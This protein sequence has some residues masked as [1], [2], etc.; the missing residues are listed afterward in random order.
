MKKL[1]FLFFL[2]FTLC[3]TGLI[4]QKPYDPKAI[5]PPSPDV[6]TGTLPNG[7]KYYIKFNQKPAQKVELRLAVNAGSILEDNDQQ[8][9]AHFMEHMNF[10][11]LKHF[12]ANELVQYLQSIGVGFGNDLNAF[13]GFDETQYML[14][15][16]SDDSNKVDK[17]FTVISDWSG[18][19]LLTTE[20]I[21]KERGVIL[22]ES[23]IGKGADDR[24]M[25]K[26]LPSL[27]N[28]SKYA[29]RLPIGADSIIEKF[30]YSV[31]RRFYTDW[32]RPNLQAVIVV[33]DMPVEKAEKM[34]AEKFGNFKNPA[35]PRPRQAIFEV[36]PFTVSKA[37]MVSDKEANFTQISIVCSA[38]PSHPVITEGDFLNRMINNLFFSMMSMRL[39]ELKNSAKPPF[40]YAYTYLGGWGRGY[41]NFA[42][43]A[44]C[45]NQQMKPAIEA[46]MS[47]CMRVKKFGLTKDE[48]SRA[49]AMMLADYEKRYN[50]RNKT[51][52][53]NLIWQFASNFYENEAIPG[54]EWERNFVKQNIDLIDLNSF[55]SI[56][57]KITFNDKYFCYVTAK[58]EADLPTDEQLKAWIDNALKKN[59]EAYKENA[60]AASLL[61]AEPK[62]GTV[63]NTEKNEKLGTTTLTLS[64]GAT[65]CLKQTDFKNDEIIF[66]G[67]RFGG[68]SLY[69]AIDYPSAQFSNN[70]VEEMGYGDFSKSDLTK[71]LSGKE[72]SVTPTIDMYT[73]Y[74]N[75]KSTVKDLETLFQLIYLKC[76]SPRK[77]AEAF[78]SYISREKQQLESIKQNPQYLFM[79]TAYNTFYG[80]N[81]R[82]H[83]LE[84][85]SIYNLMK[86]ENALN[87]YKERL[88]NVN[89]MYYTFVG[90]FTIDQILP[91]IQK[92]IA[93]LPSGNSINMFRDLGIL[94]IRG[95][96]SFTLNKGSEQ[97]AML[98]H[99]FTGKMP[100][101]PDDNFL[102]SQLNGVL[103]NQIIDT[104]REKM[105]AIYGGGCGGSIA[106]FPREEFIIQS[107]FPCSPQNIEKVSKAFLGLIESAKAEG[108]ITPKDLERVR[109]PALEHFKVNIKTN[110]YWLNGLQNAFLYGT[111]PERI[112]TYEMR[113][114]AVTPEQ[115]VQTARK[116]YTRQ[117]TLKA[118]WLPEVK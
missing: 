54:I 52:S 59:V 87:F 32:Y 111:D 39:E 112:I 25:K 21:D 117:N 66:K 15:V 53:G 61:K 6:K 88:C 57:N 107:Q 34:I 27:M 47:E 104:I 42:A 16:P 60:I 24:M 49:K 20:E 115:L 75:G 76:T 68:F 18:A 28:G 73:E 4:A 91:L 31:L 48:L 101:N 86:M 92:Y 40:V 55:D 74:I 13:T 17:A 77:D 30:D 102:L 5:I 35:S 8:G 37:M 113:L 69:E 7:L 94:P 80:G 116:F 82:A 72:V 78:K 109:E 11:G 36:K 65:V 84:N 58:T 97:Q 26:W 98:S 93:S 71:F 67:S 46:L 106:K 1:T 110:D 3:L 100:Y 45:G 90:N 81:K 14:P 105:S 70:L 56:R 118:E 44:M 89:G 10:N 64:N 79:D 50:E 29:D 51:E 2:S 62:P 108:G 114:K 43:N 38:Q 83:L 63:V 33:G 95:E 12:P 99:F 103:N 9:L 19:A 41:E 85:P 22:A 96:H 23:R